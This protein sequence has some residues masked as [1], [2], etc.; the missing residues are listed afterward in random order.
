MSQFVAGACDRT[1][2]QTNWRAGSPCRTYRRAVCLTNVR[3]VRFPCE[4]CLMRRSHGS[5][6]LRFSC[7][8]KGTR[9]QHQRAR[10]LRLRYWATDRLSIDDQTAQ[11][12][13]DQPCQ[14]YSHLQITILLKAR[15]YALCLYV[16]AQTGHEMRSI[17][18][19]T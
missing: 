4:I 5:P 12:A 2:R 9:P 6:T 19:V 10:M 13:S 8:N 7:W 14:P 16:M 15:E 11:S 18:C 17:G 3:R 1:G